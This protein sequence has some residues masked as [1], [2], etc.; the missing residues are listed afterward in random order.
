M[1]LDFCDVAL[2]GWLG[3]QF[4]WVAHGNKQLSLFY[5]YSRSDSDVYTH[6]RVCMLA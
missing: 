2:V 5:L 4:L 3:S 1:R 6:T